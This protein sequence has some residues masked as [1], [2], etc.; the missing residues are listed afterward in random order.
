MYVYNPVIDYLRE[1]YHPASSF[2]AIAVYANV[3]FFIWAIL[4]AIC[5]FGSGLKLIMTMQKQ[6][7]Y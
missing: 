3:I 6:K 2:P 1:L 7:G 5:L 4:A